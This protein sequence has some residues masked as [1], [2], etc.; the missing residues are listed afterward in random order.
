MGGRKVTH[1]RFPLTTFNVMT[2]R[3]LFFSLLQD[4]AGAGEIEETLPDDRDWTLGDLIERLQDRI[5]GLRNWDG[6]LL[7]AVNQTWADRGTALQDGD[8][9]AIMPPVQGG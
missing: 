9:V 4:L 3:I 7:L 1:L 6:R 8:E 2:L 5:P